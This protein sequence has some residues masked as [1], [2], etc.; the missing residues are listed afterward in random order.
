[1]VA[2]I[3]RWKM[4]RDKDEYAGG[5][6]LDLSKAFDTI[7]HELLIAKMY[8]Y[9]FSIDAL[10][11]VHSYLSD[12]WHRTKIDGSFSTWKKILAGMPQGSVNGPKWFNIY[13]NDLFFLFLNT[14]VCNIA[15][16]TTPCACDADLGVLLHNLESD[17]ASA[18]LWFDANYM[19]PNQSK[20]HFLAPSHSPELL[21]IQVGE[22]IIWESRKEKLL[23]VIVDRDLTFKEHIENLCKKAG[24]KVTALARLV[25]IVSREK[26]KI[27]MCAF[28][29]SQFCYC[30]L[31]WMFC[32]SRKLNKRINKIHERG[33]RM[34][35]DDYTSSFD[36]LLKA[37]GSVTVH[38]RNI[39][40]VAVEMFKVKNG[41]CP[42]IMKD[43]FQLR[44][45]SNGT[46]KFIIPS[47]NNEYMGKLSLRYFGPVVWETMLPNVYKE[48]NNLAKFKDDIKAW[49]PDCNCR[50]CKTYIAGVGF[51][52]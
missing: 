31:V 30:P 7:N 42:E 22:Q 43:L 1:M 28:I 2:M 37:D 45:D 27:L 33:L 13:L 6:L 50:L 23:G 47:V 18:L 49:V 3:E 48:I 19:K 41:F 8:A 16:D 39:Q 29:E 35:Y 5:V 17:T 10:K 21:W 52:E 34:V 51:T 9:G 26:K 46:S 24:A 15:D 12:R 11:I 36:E 4:A 14:E 40:L 20:C 32:H 38:H 44:Q 25:K